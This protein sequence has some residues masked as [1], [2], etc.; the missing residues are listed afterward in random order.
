[1]LKQFFATLFENDLYI[2]VWE[3]RVQIR[4]LQTGETITDEPL[5][6]LTRGQT[7]LNTIHAF[8]YPAKSF[9]YKADVEVVNPFSHPRLLVA[10]FQQAER[11]IKI[12]V[13]KLCRKKLFSPSPRIVFQPMEKLE[14]GITDI[15]MRVYRELCLG[16]GAREVVIYLGSPVLISNMK[17]DEIKQKGV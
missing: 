16:A 14:G 11:V 9:A 6:A 4:N 5:L 17:F 15:E 3:D 1:M 13:T 2:Q 7:N 10:N 8:G 12:L